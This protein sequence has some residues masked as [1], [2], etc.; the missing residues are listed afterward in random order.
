MRQ[1]TEKGF[2]LIELLI[3][4]AI[5]GI[6][7]AIAIPNLLASRSA[8]TTY[9][10]TAGGGSY[11]PMN[12]LGSQSLV[13]SVLASGQ[14]SGYNFTTG[15]APAASTTTFTAGA[16][17]VTPSGITATGTR[18]FCIN[19]TGVLLANPTASGTVP[20]DCTASGFSSIGN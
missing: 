8:A 11:G 7:A 2:S 19:Q 14:K 18:D 13:D 6:I 9:Q 10:S 4:V 1:S 17:P 20:T 16:T 5:I 12:D 3:V 15:T